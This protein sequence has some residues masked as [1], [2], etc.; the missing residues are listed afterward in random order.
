MKS[1]GIFLLF[2]S[3]MYLSVE[4]CEAQGLFRKKSSAAKAA[5]DLKKRKKEAREGNAFNAEQPFGSAPDYRRDDQLWSSET[6]YTALP[7]TGNISIATPSRYGIGNN[8]ELSTMLP[9]N[10]LVPNL[11]LKKSYPTAKLLIAHRHALYTP[12]IG[13]NWAQNNGYNAVVADSV[14]I[15]A[16]LSLRNELIVSYPIGANPDCGNGQPYLILTGGIALD[17]GFSLEENN[18]THIDEHILGSRSSTLTGQGVVLSARLRV[19][20]YLN[21]MMAIEGDIKAFAS[22]SIARFT[23]EQHTGL[24]IFLMRNFSFTVGY[25]A[26]CGHFEKSNFALLPYADLSIYFGTKPHR[27]FGLFKHGMF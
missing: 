7:N 27:Q 9:L 4:T 19:D 2:V 15:P 11:I 3:I 21:N 22:N 16:I 5:S 26:S 13:F 25:I 23:L 10:Y 17:A 6:A 24:H 1:A 14:N 18:L 8:F 20:G 12:T